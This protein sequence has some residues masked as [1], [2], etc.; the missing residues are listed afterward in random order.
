MIAR[1]QT[2]HCTIVPRRSNAVSAAACRNAH[3]T[4]INDILSASPS[5]KHRSAT[6]FIYPSVEG[7]AAS[8]RTSQPSAAIK[9]P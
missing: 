5:L 6:R 3:T 7:T 4:I 1:Q 8:R 2:D 9:S